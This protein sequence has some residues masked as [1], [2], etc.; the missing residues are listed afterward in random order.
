MIGSK[1]AKQN[2]KCDRLCALLCEFVNDT[3]INLS[4]PVEA[5]VEA[6]R[7]I[8]DSPHAVFVNVN[9]A[10]IGGDA[11]RKNESLASADVVGNAFEALEKLKAKEA[12]KANKNNDT[13]GDQTR[14]EFER[15]GFHNAR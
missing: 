2:V 13:K 4:G 14:D 10:Q 8:P 7:A 11:R 12:E 6:D 5:E 3:A 1:F 9:E 15:L